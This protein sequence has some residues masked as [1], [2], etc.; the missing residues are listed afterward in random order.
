MNDFTVRFGPVAGTGNGRLYPID[1]RP[2]LATAIKVA[3]IKHSMDFGFANV[4]QEITCV[5][6]FS[7]SS[8]TWV[9]VTAEA[10]AMEEN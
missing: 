7:T 5:K 1:D 3:K 10:L 4:R 8:R 9:D 6:V 2:D